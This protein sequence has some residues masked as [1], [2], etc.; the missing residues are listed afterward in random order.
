MLKGL[1]FFKL[2]SSD[3]LVYSVKLSLPHCQPSKIHRFSFAAQNKTCWLAFTADFTVAKVNVE[4]GF[5]KSCCAGVSPNSFMWSNV[6]VSCTWAISVFSPCAPVNLMQDLTQL[7]IHSHG[8]ESQ[9]CSCIFVPLR[10]PGSYEERVVLQE[11]QQRLWEG[12]LVGAVCVF[13]DGEACQVLQRRKTLLHVVQRTQELKR[14]AAVFSR[15]LHWVRL[16]LGPDGLQVLRRLAWGGV[17]LDEARN[18]W[19]C[20]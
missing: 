3:N 8:Q 16:G 19:E 5:R 11:A 17:V 15:A 4:I 12:Q 2:K 6:E 9:P 7:H 1:K 14:N 13:V 20:L 18:V 10:P